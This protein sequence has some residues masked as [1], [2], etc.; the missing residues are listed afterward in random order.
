MHPPNTAAHATAPELS[1]LLA[2][3]DDDARFG[4][5]ALS[6]AGQLKGRAQRQAWQALLALLVEW[7]TRVAGLDGRLIA[8]QPV[9]RAQL[10]HWC[11]QHGAQGGGLPDEVRPAI[12]RW[13][14]SAAELRRA[15]WFCTAVQEVLVAVP[16]R[17]VRHRQ[18]DRR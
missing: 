1:L 11:A 18:G 2:S 7:D 3:P 8:L 4:P 9:L 17:R 15:R 13:L 12:G 6:V 5:L 14:R 16:L 10:A